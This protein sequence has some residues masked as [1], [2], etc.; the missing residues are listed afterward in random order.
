MLDVTLSNSLTDL[1][2]RIKAEHEAS[3][4]AIKRGLEHAVACGR[5]LNCCTWQQRR[6]VGTKHRC[7]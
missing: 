7:I 6:A 4:T 1:A 3:S 5:L 2:A